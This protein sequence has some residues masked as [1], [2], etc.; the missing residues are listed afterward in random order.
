[1]LA[2]EYLPLL[3]VGLAPEPLVKAQASLAGLEQFWLFL[4]QAAMVL[5]QTLAQEPLMHKVHTIERMDKSIAT[6]C[7]QK[8]QAHTKG[9]HTEAS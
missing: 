9:E 2:Q 4:A 1:M 7:S 5:Q 8:Q 3:G 6:E